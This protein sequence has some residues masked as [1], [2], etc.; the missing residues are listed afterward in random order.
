MYRDPKNVAA[1]SDEKTPA[2][3]NSVLN[4]EDAFIGESSNIDGDE[5]LSASAMRARRYFITT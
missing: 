1:I 5:A 4:E 3:K 2:A